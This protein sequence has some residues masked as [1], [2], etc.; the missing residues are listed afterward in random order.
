MGGVLAIMEKQRGSAREDGDHR[1]LLCLQ[2]IFRSM[3]SGVGFHNAMFAELLRDTDQ[4]LPQV[5]GSSQL[6][7]LSTLMHHPL[8]T[9]SVLLPVHPC[10]QKDEGSSIWG[11]RQQ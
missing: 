5:F 9:V 10:I 1:R 4:G 8:E 3:A 6:R 2:M 11:A 7:A